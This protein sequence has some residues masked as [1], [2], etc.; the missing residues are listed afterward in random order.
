MNL[1]YTTNNMPAH[2]MIPGLRRRCAVP[3]I[4]LDAMVGLLPL[5]G[6]IGLKWCYSHRYS[7]P[8]PKTKRCQNHL[9]P[10]SLVYDKATQAPMRGTYP[11]A[12]LALV[13]G[14]RQF[15]LHLL[16]NLAARI[17]TLSDRTRCPSFWRAISHHGL[18]VY[19]SDNRDR[20]PLAVG[21][22]ELCVVSD[23]FH[24]IGAVRSRYDSI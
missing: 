3:L 17:A 20:S 9:Q 13:Y 10:L 15:G 16:F 21:V 4:W 14:L 24:F 23:Q 18:V 5:S 22:L 19:T 6:K 2:I 11:H 8:K 12:R 7:F 1:V